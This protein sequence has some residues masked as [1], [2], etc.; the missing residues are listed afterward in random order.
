VRTTYPESLAE[1]IED[2]FGYYL[3]TMTRTTDLIPQGTRWTDD[4]FLR[5]W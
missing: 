5:R 4:F 3:I 1:E 2:K